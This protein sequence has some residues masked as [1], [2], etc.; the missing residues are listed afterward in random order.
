MARPPDGVGAF[1][2]PDQ[3]NRRTLMSM[4]QSAPSPIGPEVG[5]SAETLAATNSDQWHV[6]KIDRA[7]LKELMK[8][9]DARGIRSFTLWFALLAV[10]GYLGYLSWG[11]WL[12]VPAFLAYGTLYATAEGRAHELGHGTPFKNRRLNEALLQI[13]SFMALREGYYARWRHA[14]H[15]TNT[16]LTDHDPEIQVK[17]P[18]DLA[19]ILLDFLHLNL[20]AGE[21]T[22]IGQHALGVIASDVRSYVPMT[23]QR[24]MIWASR[25]Y[26]LVFSVVLAYAISIRSFLPLMYVVLPRFYGAWFFQLC[27]LTQHAG[28]D[29]NVRDH[30]LNTRT[31]YMNPVAQFL[32]CN[33]NYH[34]EHHM[35]PMVPCYA[36]G[37]LH[38][39]IKTQLPKTYKG[40]YDVYRE[41]IPALWRQSKDE[42]YY[43]R[44]AIPV[45]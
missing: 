14:Q 37:D 21:V 16:I 4:S 22:V 32:Y 20:G 35:F 27:Q 30:R 38:T 36:L 5:S 18:A 45:D 26:V 40:F 44:R 29:Q 25:I 11:T 1:A 6:C 43:V 3:L 34:I 7:R 31:V 41:V 9:S 15:H 17:R 2:V 24:K 39:E 23:E 42:R 8:R 33:M 13:C 10:T 12:A 28:L 19:K